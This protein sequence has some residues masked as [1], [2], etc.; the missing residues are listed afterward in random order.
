MPRLARKWKSLPITYFLFLEKK[1]IQLLDENLK[2]QHFSYKR[3]S[4]KLGFF[5]NSQVTDKNEID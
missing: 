5:R 2:P 1:L 4:K 3:I